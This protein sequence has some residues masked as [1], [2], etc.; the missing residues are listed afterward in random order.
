[1]KILITGAAGFIGRALVKALAE[2]ND[3]IGIDNLNTLSDISIKYARLSDLGI[4]IDNISYGKALMSRT[5]SFFRFLKLDVADREGLPRLF[6]DIHFDCVVHLAAQAGVRRSMEMPFAYAE[7][8]L[9]GFL[10]VLECCRKSSPLPRLVFASS[11]SVY[12]AQTKIPFSENDPTDK[13]VSFYAATKKADELM[14]QAYCALYGISVVGLRYFSVYGPWG[15]PDMAPFIFLR[16]ILRGIPVHLFNDGRMSRDFTFIDD[17][18]ECTRRVIVHSLVDAPLF[19]IYN[20]GHSVPVTLYELISVL[21]LVAGK[22]AIVEL[23][24]MQHGDVSCTMADVSFFA[25]DYGYRPLTSLQQG[26]VALYRWF[27]SYPKLWT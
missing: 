4:P 9:L 8:N 27:L 23:T 1:M 22:K 18:V 5:L 24:G 25:R 11:S 19:R 3:V 7:A 13:P 26:A 2:D 10:N 21:E 16:A 15:R 14:A 6:A 12:G 17:V 20:I